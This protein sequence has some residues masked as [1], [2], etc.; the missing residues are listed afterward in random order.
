MVE[1]VPEAGSLVIRYLL[2]VEGTTGQWVDG[3]ISNRLPQAIELTLGPTRYDTLPP[4]LRYPLLVS[5]ETA[6]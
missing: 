1:L 2:P 5:V 3:W 6:R 4:L